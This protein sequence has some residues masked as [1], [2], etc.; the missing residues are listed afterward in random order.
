[1][2]AHDR[3]SDEASGLTD[4]HEILWE[5]EY[6]EPLPATRPEEPLRGL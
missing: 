2:A 3:A 1:M 6:G 5:L 4:Q